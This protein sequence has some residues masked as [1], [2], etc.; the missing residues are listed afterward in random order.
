MK[1]SDEASFCKY[2]I[3]MN[4]KGAVKKLRSTTIYAPSF[5]YDCEI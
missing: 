3:V 1:Y 5:L 2:P 4:K